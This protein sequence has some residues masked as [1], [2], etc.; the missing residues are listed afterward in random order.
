MDWS[1]TVLRVG[2]VCVVAMIENRLKKRHGL[3][4]TKLYFVWKNIVNRCCRKSHHN[5]NWY[6]AK[7]ITL[8]DEWRNSPESF[9]RWCVSNGYKEG[10]QIDRIDNSKGYSPCN[11]RFVSRN[12]NQRNTS[13]NLRIAFAGETH[14]LVEWCEKLGRPYDLIYGRIRKGWTVEKAFLE[15]VN[16]SQRRI[17]NRDSS[18]RASGIKISYN[19]EEHTCLEW[20]RIIGVPWWTISNRV[21]L[22]WEVER[23][24]NTPVRKKEKTKNE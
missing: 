9:I 16:I 3:S 18:G 13:A 1:F 2:F 15:P 24:F 12:E 4:K 6:G 5:Y 14:T 10:L 20:S 22:G 7:G 8:C 21:K 11:C 17:L 19:G 23:I